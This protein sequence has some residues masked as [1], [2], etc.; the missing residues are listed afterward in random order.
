MSCNHATSGCEYPSGECTGAC[1]TEQG[2]ESQRLIRATTEA[3]PKRY[4][5]IVYEIHSSGQEQALLHAANHEAVSYSHAIEQRD[6]LLKAL[7][8]YRAK[9]HDLVIHRDELL[10]KLRGLVEA[11]DA[12]NWS[13][14]QTTARFDPALNDARAAISINDAERRELEAIVRYGLGT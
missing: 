10:Q 11:L 6:E 5:T 12:T 9:A 7:N 14:W 8:H 13:S 3:A 1:M 2:R 4:L